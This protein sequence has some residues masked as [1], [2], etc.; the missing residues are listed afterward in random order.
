MSK[1]SFTEDN[2]VQVIKQ[3][4]GVELTYSM[5]DF[6]EVIFTDPDNKSFKVTPCTWMPYQNSFSGD[7]IPTE[8]FMNMNLLFVDYIMYHMKLEWLK[9]NK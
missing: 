4:T 7:G 3:R 9:D 2:V 1:F 8:E 5:S 6:G